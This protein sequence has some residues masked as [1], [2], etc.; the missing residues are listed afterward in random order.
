MR[1]IFK[2]VAVVHGIELIRAYIRLY[3]LTEP[4]PKVRKGIHG[5]VPAGKDADQNSTGR[6]ST[7]KEGFESELLS[8]WFKF[9][10][11]AWWIGVVFILDLLSRL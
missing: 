11:E 2:A 4:C 1:W 6:Q 10:I 3:E 8:A 5:I 7:K 9:R